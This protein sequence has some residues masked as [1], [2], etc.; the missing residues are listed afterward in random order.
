MFCEL[1]FFLH[2]LSQ[3]NFLYCSKLFIPTKNLNTTH[4]PSE[5]KQ[6]IEHQSR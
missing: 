6:V 3:G 2:K 5:M 4:A 1:F